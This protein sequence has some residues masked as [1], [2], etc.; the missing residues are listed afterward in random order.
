MNMPL[1]VLAISIPTY[2]RAVLVKETLASIIKEVVSYNLQ[3]SVKIY[4]FDNASEDETLEVVSTILSSSCIEYEIVTSKANI[5]AE[6][7]FDR[8]CRYPLEEYSWVFGSD[9]IVDEGAINKV[10]HYLETD[11]PSGGMSVGYRFLYD[12]NLKT[13]FRLLTP[14]LGTQ[15]IVVSP[16]KNIGRCASMSYSRT[17][18]RLLLGY[19]P[20]ISSSILRTEA[21]R[22]SV[23]SPELINGEGY[24]FLPWFYSVLRDFGWHYSGIDAVVARR[25]SSNLDDASG[26]YGKSSEHAFKVNRSLLRIV[27]N[28][29]DLPFTLISRRNLVGSYI[30]R[31]YIGDL[32]RFKLSGGGNDEAMIDYYNEIYSLYC[33]SRLTMLNFICGTLRILPPELFQVAQKIYRK[34]VGR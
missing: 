5:G 33:N 30:Y 13:G 23:K 10:L 11:L 16:A 1:K 24:D 21:Y 31:Y 18:S 34:I 17:L 25:D 6:R 2:N 32:I 14:E 8:C 20:F 9:D 27:C 26:F 29:L 12:G 4:V 28:R 22:Q 7:N 3:N 15:P 19:F